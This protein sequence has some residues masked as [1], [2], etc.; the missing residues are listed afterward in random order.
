MKKFYSFAML[1]AA[2]AVAF[3]SCNEVEPQIQ[4]QEQEEVAVSKSTVFHITASS[5]DTKTV[6]GDKGST[7]YPTRWTTNK[8]VAFS[9]DEADFVEGTPTLVDGGVS[10]TFD[11]EL[12]GEATAGTIYAFSPRGVY[13]KNNSENNVPGFTSISKDYHDVYLNIPTTQTPLAN[14]VDE[15]AQAIVGSASY[16]NGN[17][18]LSMD[19]SHIVAYGKMAITNF[20]G[21]AIKTVEITFPENVAGSSCRYHY[22]TEVLDNF[23]TNTITLLPTNVVNNTFWFAIAPFAGTSGDVV[24]KVTDEND[25]L[26]Q[27]RFTLTETKPLTFTAGVVSLFSVNFSGIS[28]E[29]DPDAVFTVSTIA[30]ANGWSNGIAYVEEDY[31]DDN[32]NT[33]VTVQCSGTGNNGKYY[34]SDESW[35]LYT[36]GD[37]KLIVS[38]APGVLISKIHIDMANGGELSVDGFNNTTGIWSGSAN[39]VTFVATA[40]TKITKIEVWYSETVKTKLA[41]PT[42][43]S[44]AVDANTANKINASWNAVDNAGSYVVTASPTSGDAISAEVSSTLYSFSDLEYATSYTVS[45]YAVPSDLSSFIA[46]D[47]ATAESVTTGANSK[48]EW[49]LVTSLS[50]ITAGQYVIVASTSTKTGYFPSADNTTSAPSYITTGLTI[51]NNKIT[52]AVTDAMYFEFTGTTSEM[53]IKNASGSYLYAINNNN[54]LR[55]GGTSDTWTISAHKSKEANAFQFVDATQSRY[56]GVYSNQDWRCYT[57]VDATNF[58]N[59]TGSSK[60]F[61]YKKTGG[62]TP[63]VQETCETPVISCTDNTVTITCATSGATIYYTTDGSDPTSSSSLY[64]APFEITQNC[65]VKAIAIKE[66]FTN[67]SIVSQA[68]TYTAPAAPLATITCSSTL[69]VENSESDGTIN[70]TYEHAEDYDVKVF[71]DSNCTSEADS[72]FWFTADFEDANNSDYDIYWMA[73][74]NTGNARY[75]YILI[76]V[77]NIDS[78]LT[79]TKITVTQAAGGVPQLKT[80]TLTITEIQSITNPKLAYG[81]G[82][83][84]EDGDITWTIDGNTDA[85]SRPW[86]QLKNAASQGYIEIS[87]PSAIKEVRLS[88]SNASNEKGGILDMSMHGNYSGDIHLKTSA[89]VGT[90]DNDDVAKVSSVNAKAVTITVG[91]P[92]ATTLYIKTSAAARVWGVEVD[93]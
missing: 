1:F 75:A 71:E 54:G 43:L 86:I 15:S 33:N 57:T 23:N 77:A 5:V 58:T 50:D 21:D 4:E 30:D 83:V 68:C 19:F 55:V 6:F 89:A 26:Y 10:A 79:S 24:V 7:G 11:V 46:S 32:G 60:L 91:N 45:V 64:S 82:V 48:P 38:G 92:S 65:T 31:A 61:L 52:S 47:S 53:S 39:S 40:N 28:P 74:S 20:A 49:V 72:D 87:A 13:D 85:A 42:G 93:Y 76:T 29:V 44:V 2:V 18:N 3:S 51:L 9:R 88:I 56:I 27:K 37:G 35:R 81:T 63:P 78:E 67:S 62:S 16:D 34:T 59:A 8:D 70:V 66:Y 25:D 84:Y 36:S 17:P 41:T 14:S 80:E 69:A 90:S 22:D 73:E 12:P